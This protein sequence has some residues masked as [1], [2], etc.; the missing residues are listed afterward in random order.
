M[1]PPPDSHL[2]AWKR[3]SPET[4]ARLGWSWGIPYDAFIAQEP[5]RMSGPCLFIASFLAQDTEGGET[6]YNVGK[7]GNS[8]QV[9]WMHTDVL[10]R[11]PLWVSEP[12]KLGLLL[13]GLRRCTGTE[14]ITQK[15][16][17][18]VSDPFSHCLSQSILDRVVTL[19]RPPKMCVAVTHPVAVSLGR[20]YEVGT[21]RFYLIKT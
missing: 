12:A 18:L 13:L 1:K 8:A 16:K 20:V 10:Q 6:Q 11:E 17:P 5:P 19:N 15:P 4:P 3:A 21:T 9:R 2:S 7:A 14:G